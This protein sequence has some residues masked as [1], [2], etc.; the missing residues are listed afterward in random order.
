MPHV[1][2]D[3]GIDL[4]FFST[5]FSPFAITAP[6][7]IKL[8]DF[9][10]SQNKKAVLVHAVVIDGKNQQFLIEVFSKKEK[11]TVRLYPGTDPEKTNGVKTSLGCLAKIIQK[12]FPQLKISK[13]NI[14]EFI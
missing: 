13:T 14:S 11:T 7:I 1:V 5:K 6:Y 4:E 10:I 9:F 2:F 12:E 8:D 3:A